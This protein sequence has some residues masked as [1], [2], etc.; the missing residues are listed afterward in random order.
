MPRFF[1]WTDSLSPR[2][3]RALFA[4]FL[5]SLVLAI[6]APFVWAGYHAWAGRDALQRYHSAEAARHFQDCLRL[7]PWS[8]DPHLYLLAARAARRQGDYDEADRLLRVCQDTLH[9]NGGEAVL[10]WAMLRATR[11]DLDDTAESLRNA[12][13]RDPQLI[14]LVL[15]ALAEGYLTLSRILDALR[16]T[17]D[18]LARQ[19]N[20]PQAWF[21][22]GKVHR[23]VGAPQ[24]TADDYQHV[25]ALDPER[26]EARWWL[27][28]A[29]LDI[30]EYHKAYEQLRLVQKLR[31]DE[32]VRVY[33]GLCL[34]R[35]DRD[36]EAIPLLDGV[37]AE[38]PE[39]G[40]AL[41]TR[42]QIA[43]AQGRF[44]E[45]EPWL[46]HAARELPYDYR[47]QNAL[48]E[49][50]RQQGK[51][52]EADAQ[53]QRT[54]VLYER[55]QRQSEILNHLMSQKPDDLQLQC[56]LA[57]LYMQLGQPQVGEA[58]LLHALRRDRYYRPALEA[59]ANFYREQGDDERAEVYRQR[60]DK[61]EQR[62]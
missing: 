43:L 32:E 3:R 33:L 18:W 25:L 42:G 60:A 27:G 51:K 12:A 2:R 59:L 10:E 23:Q 19:P 14:P 44:A 40:M 1:A 17:D 62:P 21:V 37:L 9:D 47:A 54:D 13:R 5:G 7:W 41:L 16:T 48:W 20:N 26:G 31:D 6:A 38:H 56:E 35:L 36:E 11:G 52:K 61:A 57:Q 46:Q 39:S 29:L 34:H 53:R 4:V 49:C 28:R 15:E 24:A 55:R 8:R 50:L 45:A 22:R 58:W 30:G